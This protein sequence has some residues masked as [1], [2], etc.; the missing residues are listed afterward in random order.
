VGAR[1]IS[2]CQD[3]LVSLQ[4]RMLDR[5]MVQSA[6]EFEEAPAKRTGTAR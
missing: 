2:R 6:I 4:M 5:P 3:G 1:S